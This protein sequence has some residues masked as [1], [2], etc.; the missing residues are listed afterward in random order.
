MKVYPARKP[1]TTPAH[2]FDA[3]GA[4]GFAGAQ[5]PI[6]PHDGTLA[7]NSGLTERSTGKAPGIL[8]DDGKVAALKG[9]QSI[10]PTPER[11]ALWNDWQEFHGFGIGV[12]GRNHPALD[13]D[14]LDKKLG[15]EIAH[16][17]EGAVGRAPLPQRFGNFP[18]RLITTHLIEG[19]EPVRKRVWRL[20]RKSDGSDAGKVELLGD[21]Q[22]YV[23]EG[24]HRDTGKPYRWTRHPVDEP[25]AVPRV[26]PD[27]FDDFGKRLAALAER[28]GLRVVESGAEAGGN[29]NT[30]ALDWAGPE[31][32]AKLL[33]KLPNDYDDRDKWIKVSHAIKAA[34]G[35]RED[36][37]DWCMTWKGPNT[38]EDCEDRWEGFEPD[39]RVGW[40]VLVKELRA[41]GIDDSQ[42]TFD[43][44]PPMLDDERKTEKPKAEPD[45][46]DELEPWW[47]PDY[48]E[49][50]SWLYANHHIRG[51]IT[52]TVAPGGFGKTSLSI[53][54]GLAMATGRRLL[55]HEPDE[56]VRV[57]L[58]NG[59]D[60]PDEMNRRVAAARRFHQVT[61]A[62]L[63]GRLFV[64]AGRKYALTLATDSR[65]GVVINE[66]AFKKLRRFIRK[67]RIDVVILDPLIAAHDL[68]ESDNS[69]MGRL[70]RKLARV[71]EKMNC[72][73][74]LVHHMRKLGRDQREH[75][76]EDWRGA[77]AVVAACRSVRLLNGMM[78]DDEEAKGVSE[79]QR[80][81]YFRITSGK[82]N[83][84]PSVKDAWHEFASVDLDNGDGFRASD[85][86][87]VV[88][89]WTPPAPGT[90]R[91]DS[92]RVSE[93]QRR[94]AS[95][96][97]RDNWQARDWV[98]HVIGEV[99]GIGTVDLK[100]KR[101][102]K[103]LQERLIDEG[104][105]KVDRGTDEKSN[106]RP[107][108]RVGMTPDAKRIED[109]KGAFPDDLPPLSSPPIPVKTRKKGR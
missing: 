2:D 59:E 104:M 56:P 8:T 77:I 5:V 29:D 62:E 74:E 51:F 42:F 54:E 55:H 57:L 17:F 99:W 87:G 30:Q 22:Q 52:G 23:V 11:C 16:C 18:K 76:V 69:K 78:G 20:L 39:G 66:V 14:V 43:D 80:W 19:A 4:A 53:V 92:D 96:S 71:A 107:F 75:T 15:D 108:V 25:G 106:G 84:A 32:V 100:D 60:P 10:E 7:G 98:G 73:I 83:M 97:Y 68:P 1:D 6:S 3:W 101:K 41:H 105:L 38:R 13:I 58:W 21:G 35:H 48:I 46:W 33:K 85:S 90:V 31:K 102:V 9:W 67:H 49:P 72:A 47:E 50:R 89:T 28:H 93:L 61:K 40:D 94:V 45:A 103:K 63:G 36:Y 24:I 64:A 12:R 109:A 65:D 91:L 44:P 86:V 27:V 79:E 70:S 37:V 95:G 34:G 81:R 26:H 88:R 82:A